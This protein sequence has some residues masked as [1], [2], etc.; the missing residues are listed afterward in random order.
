[1]SAT[2]GRS[3]RLL[4]HLTCSGCAKQ[5]YIHVDD[6]AAAIA[7]IC[8]TQQAG[9]FYAGGDEV[10]RIAEMLQVVCDVLA[11][12]KTPARIDGP[13]SHDALVAKSRALPLTHP[14]RF[15]LAKDLRGAAIS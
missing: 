6:A 9:L 4:F 3:A 2:A 5:N 1:M 8:D 13:D 14:M 12:G 10:L 11:P 7:H 15:M